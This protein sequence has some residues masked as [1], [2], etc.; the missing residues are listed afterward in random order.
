M[1]KNDLLVK[2]EKYVQ[3]YRAQLEKNDGLTMSVLSSQASI[4]LKAITNA[5]KSNEHTAKALQTLR[6]GMDKLEEAV[7]K[8]DR[9]VS[10]KALDLMEKALAN[11]RSKQKDQKESNQ[12]PLE[13]QAES[14]PPA[15]SGK[16]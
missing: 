11:L 14:T 8:G 1:N 9:K 6:E 2:M 3:T 5:V 16:C 4:G 10:A 12:P 7:K 13:L 15:D